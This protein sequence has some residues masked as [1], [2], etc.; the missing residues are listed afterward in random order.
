MKS[1]RLASAF[2]KDLKRITKR[3]YNRAL[4]DTIVEALRE[5]K[6]LPPARRDH[7]LKGVWKGRRECHIGPDCSS[8]MRRVM[9]SSC[10][11]VPAHMPISSQNNS[12][13]QSLN[14][15]QKS[16]NRSGESSG[17]KCAVFPR[18][19]H[20]VGA[21]LTHAYAAASSPRSADAPAR[22]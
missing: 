18:H 11:C 6:P 12:L 7:P 3:R 8:S 17:Y 19:R 20:H 10:S 13:P 9:S 16:L 4:L 14:S 22:E 21:E 1:L 5:D 2:K 15:S